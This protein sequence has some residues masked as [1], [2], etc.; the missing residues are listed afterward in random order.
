MDVDDALLLEQKGKIATITLNN[1]DKLN[2]FT[3][4]RLDQL[5]GMFEEIKSNK[6]IRSVLIR[7]EGEKAFSAGLDTGMLTSGDP[8]IKGKIIE[9]GTALSQTVFYM[10]VPIVCAIAAPAVGWGCILS[11][12]SDFRYMIDE[13][14]FRLP[15]LSIGIYPATGAL[16][17]C[18][19]HFGVS[20][21]NEMLFMDKKLSTA[22]AARVGFVNGAGA[23]RDAVEKMARNAA[24]SLARLNQQVVM[25]TKMNSRLLQGI[26]YSAALDLEKRC[27]KDLMALGKD[28]DWHAKYL[29]DLERKAKEFS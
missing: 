27:F 2:T 19:M 4:E 26:E 9:S 8:G 24:R 6:K 5:R 11:M 1:P 25:Y 3:I 17:L 21:G 28:N 12:L 16:T 23:T 20:L 29:D 7:A 10:P 22:E 14:H 15:E 13:A 18:Y